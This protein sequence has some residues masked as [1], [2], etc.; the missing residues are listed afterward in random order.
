MLDQA[1]HLVGPRDRVVEA[2]GLQE[3]AHRAEGGSALSSN[4]TSRTKW[5]SPLPANSR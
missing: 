4:P 1:D 3:Q 2:G 5:F